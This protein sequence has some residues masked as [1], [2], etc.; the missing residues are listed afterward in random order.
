MSEL[1]R[2]R[3]SLDGQSSAG[4]ER[5]K[6]ASRVSGGA[7]APALMLSTPAETLKSSKSTLTSKTVAHDIGEF[8]AHGMR[9]LRLH[10]ASQV[11]RA[12]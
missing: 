1:R 7:K 6:A 12:S 2:R 10:D 11:L 8:H 5:V 4:G 9:H 3:R